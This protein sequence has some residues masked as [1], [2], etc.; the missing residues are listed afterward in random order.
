MQ[1]KQAPVVTLTIFLNE[2]V[3]QPVSHAQIAF[4]HCCLIKVVVRPR[5]QGNNKKLHAEPQRLLSLGAEKIGMYPHGLNGS[6]SHVKRP[7]LRNGDVCKTNSV[8]TNS[9]TTFVA[10]WN[11]RVLRIF[12]GRGSQ[13]VWVS[14]GG[15]P[16]HEFEPSTPKNPPCRAAM[17]VKSVQM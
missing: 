12:N 13:V 16:C 3:A 4:E 10:A 7:K 14:D 8:C 6:C 15:L 2:K 1:T 5:V 11:L 9:S 17:Q